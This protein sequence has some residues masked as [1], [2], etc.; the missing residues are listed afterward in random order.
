MDFLRGPYVRR[1]VSMMRALSVFA[2]TMVLSI[3]SAVMA[4]SVEAPQHHASTVDV[5][6]SLYPGA[7]PKPE[8]REGD[9]E[10]RTVS[11]ENVSVGELMAGKYLSND[12][13]EKV[14]GYYRDQL[15]SY[16]TVIEC[17]GGTDTRVSVR[18]GRHALENPEACS[19]DEFG[20]HL[21]ELK[22][23][24]ARDQHIVAVGPHDGGSE[25]TLVHVRAR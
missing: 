7:T 25:F 21:V 20:E 1:T 23:G 4:A 12:P 10:L 16:G 13:P 22:A 8:L 17:G 24:D 3:V 6:L 14:L 11:L 15:K 5:G 19:P 2:M 18:L 9:K